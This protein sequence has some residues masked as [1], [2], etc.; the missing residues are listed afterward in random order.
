M[1]ECHN[2]VD[3]YKHIV[4]RFD[5]KTVHDIFG[6]MYEHYDTMAFLE[7]KQYDVNALMNQMRF[8]AEMREQRR[9]PLCRVSI[10]HRESSN[11]LEIRRNRFDF[12]QMGTRAGWLS[13]YPPKS[14]TSPA[15]P[16]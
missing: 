10:S 8:I 7:T 5:E 9:C 6:I 13:P 15:V 4:G 1:D 16:P 12:L 2:M 3:E 11:Y 14:T